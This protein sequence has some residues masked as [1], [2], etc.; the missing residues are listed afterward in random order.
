MS[1]NI[2][3]GCSSKIFPP[4]C[5]PTGSYPQNTLL[6]HLPALENP[7]AG[8]STPFSIS[9]FLPMA[10]SFCPQALVSSIS[11][12]SG[13]RSIAI[14]P[15]NSLEAANTEPA[16]YINGRRISKKLCV[17]GQVKKSKNYPKPLPKMIKTCYKHDLF[18]CPPSLLPLSAFFFLS[19]FPR[20]LWP[21]RTGHYDC[22]HPMFSGFRQ[23]SLF[24]V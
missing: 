13:N 23:H 16:V 20:P 5:T 21:F 15:N 18:Y 19:V 1:L 4:F 14:L 22:L 3:L 11:L 8:K 6:P 2:T 9:R 10:F 12:S 7:T 17:G 24:R